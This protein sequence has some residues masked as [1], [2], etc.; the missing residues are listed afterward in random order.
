[1]GGRPA[2]AK[3]HQ[4][5]KPVPF[6]DTQRSVNRNSQ[7]RH[8]LDLTTLQG[9]QIIISRHSLRTLDM[10]NFSSSLSRNSPF[11]PFRLPC[12]RRPILHHRSSH[13]SQETY[14]L[15]PSLG[16]SPPPSSPLNNLETKPSKVS[17][18][19]SSD[20]RYSIT[21]FRLDFRQS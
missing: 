18:V 2:G 15:T 3:P 1:M 6:S 8:M 14:P 12:S 7:I 20:P 10:N 5:I 9:S 21:S 19:F 4:E 16:A 11:R 17:K 13:L